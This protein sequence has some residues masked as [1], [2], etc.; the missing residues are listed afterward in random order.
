MMEKQRIALFFT[1]W[2]FGMGVMASQI[3]R[4]LFN[5]AVS[6]YSKDPLYLLLGSAKEAIGDTFFLKANSYFH[7]GVSI[8]LIQH[9]NMVES[10]DRETEAHETF[11]KAYTDWVYKINSQVKVM[12]H[13]HLQGEETKEILPFLT[14]AVKLDPYNVPAILTTAYWL[15][16]YFKK[17]D[18]AIEMLKQG[19]KDNPDAW[20][21]CSHLGLNYFKFKKNYAESAAYFKKS[22]EKMDK[23]NSNEIDHRDAYYYLAESYANQGLNRQALEAYQSALS[24][25]SEKENLPVKSRIMQKIKSLS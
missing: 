20:E 21:I 10:E 22:L 3:E 8:N 18:A 24:N 12:E 4:H 1:V 5:P 7:G 25:F 16:S 23:N 19:L 11:K 6:G 17:T 13:I 2:F 14:T 15:N 9:E